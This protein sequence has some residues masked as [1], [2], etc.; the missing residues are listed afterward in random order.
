MQ[1]T[2]LLQTAALQVTE[3]VRCRKKPIALLVQSFQCLNSML[4]KGVR[5]TPC[6]SK[7]LFERLYGLRRITRFLTEL[8]RIEFH[9]FGYRVQTM[10]GFREQ[11]AA[12]FEKKGKE[13]VSGVRCRVYGGQNIHR[14]L[15]SFPTTGDIIE[16]SVVYINKNRFILH[17]FAK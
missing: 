4:Y 1:D 9:H 17:F 5:Q 14:S 10:F 15:E 16:Q 6:G 12:D 13:I 3:T 2:C 8:R 7:S 11:S